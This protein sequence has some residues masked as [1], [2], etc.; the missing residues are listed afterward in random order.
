MMGDQSSP[1]T[2]LAKVKSGDEK[3]PEEDKELLVDEE[4][5][6]DDSSMGYDQEDL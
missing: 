2:E 1:I 6:K 4:S 5:V 3:K